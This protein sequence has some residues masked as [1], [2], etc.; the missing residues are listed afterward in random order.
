MVHTRHVVGDRVSAA[1]SNAAGG[2]AGVA[3][4]VAEVATS[5]AAEVA[6]SGAASGTTSGASNTATSIA[7]IVKQSACTLVAYDVV[8]GGVFVERKSVVVTTKSSIDRSGWKAGGRVT[9][10]DGFV[11]TIGSGGGVRVFTDDL[12]LVSVLGEGRVVDSVAL[13]YADVFWLQGALGAVP[14]WW[15]DGNISKGCAENEYKVVSFWEGANVWGT[16]APVAPSVPAT[17]KA[18]QFCI[19]MPGDGRV[20]QVVSVVNA[21]GRSQLWACGVD[22][23]LYVCGDGGGSN[24]PGPMYPPGYTVVQNNYEYL[25]GEEELDVVL[26]APV[27]DG[28]DSRVRKMSTD[29]GE[30]VAVEEEEVVDVTTVEGSTV[31]SSYTGIKVQP[32]K[33]AAVALRMSDEG[34]SMCGVAESGKYY[35]E[36]MAVGWLVNMLPRPSGEGVVRGGGGQVSG[37]HA[38]R[39]EPRVELVEY[40]KQKSEVFRG[41]EGGGG[42]AGAAECDGCKGVV[43]VMHRCS[44]RPLP[45]SIDKAP[46]VTTAALA[47]D[48][49]CKGL[50]FEERRHFQNVTKGGFALSEEF[51]K[52]VEN[53]KRFRGEPKAPKVRRESFSEERPLVH[54]A[55]PLS[56]HRVCG[57]VRYLGNV[58]S[59]EKRVGWKVKHESMASKI[60]LVTRAAPAAA[61]GVA[62]AEVDFGTGEL[63]LYRAGELVLHLTPE[64]ATPDTFFAKPQPREPKEPKA[65]KV[66]ASKVGEAP[67]HV[68]SAT[69]QV[70][71][72]KPKPPTNWK[73]VLSF[74][75]TPG[76]F[77][78]NVAFRAGTQSLG[79]GFNR[80]IGVSG[81]AVSEVR[82]DSALNRVHP[83]VAVSSILRSFNGITL[84]DSADYVSR[85]QHAIKNGLGFALQFFLVDQ[86]NEFKQMQIM[87]VE[88]AAKRSQYLAPTKAVAAEVGGLGGGGVTGAAG[89]S[90]DVREGRVGWFSDDIHS[91]DDAVL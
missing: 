12:V 53:K 84:G 41:M 42:N 35:D 24:W 10:C 44:C 89:E 3:T 67:S 21:Q 32:E 23:R 5:G 16:S 15:R 48:A 88:D 39:G 74:C 14:S 64:G 2:A 90:L 36:G 49:F 87:R 46:G 7:R 66:K 18:A 11:V 17:L 72:A 26:P 69:P 81:L 31:S 61:G 79:L 86:E 76:T 19:E 40:M 75:Y 56:S 85:I 37:A 45:A 70:E 38:P 57:Q 33:I 78:L 62:C 9:C 43:G 6:T 47:V 30:E 59:I 4:A 51:G 52:R 77:M 60:G 20:R 58:K 55:L 50:V 8:Q 91:I 29:G 73:D 28:G 34:I 82:A 80:V 54:I 83:P 1:E 65:K 63:K 25:E 68:G 71:V 22:G 13:D 27:A